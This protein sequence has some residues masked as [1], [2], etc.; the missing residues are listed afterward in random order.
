MKTTLLLTKRNLTVFLRD[1]RAVFFAMLSPIILFCIYTFLIGGQ[2]EDQMKASLP[3]VSSGNIGWF[4]NS[5]LLSSLITIT[6]MTSGASPLARYVEDRSL[7]RFKDFMVSPVKRWQLVASYMLTSFTVSFAFTLLVMIAGLT[8]I[9]SH[10]HSNMNFGGIIVLLLR[11]ILLCLTYSAMAALFASLV[12]SNQAFG[13]FN[14]IWT[15]ALG[16]LSGL[17]I[18]L[19]EL[20]DSTKNFLS[21]LPFAQS[22][23]LVKDQLLEKPLAAISSGNSEFL[24]SLKESV[25]FDLTVNGHTV[26]LNMVILYLIAVFVVFIVLGVIKMKNLIR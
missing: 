20:S 7:G 22:T 15:T 21:S 10:G 26:Q 8:Y 18:P 11:I 19:D 23:L 24:S 12:N 4:V 9:A 1:K 2:V 14:A 6:A 5:F 13:G 16:F 17:Y 3:G 25:A